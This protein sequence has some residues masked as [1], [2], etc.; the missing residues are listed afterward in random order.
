MP[1]DR[2][3]MLSER[4][5]ETTTRLYESTNEDSEKNFFDDIVNFFD[6]LGKDPNAD[7]DDDMA[8]G[9][10][11]VVSLPVNSIKPGGLRLFLMFYLMGMQ[12]TP[13]KGTWIP[14]QPTTEDDVYVIDCWF[15]DQSAVLT[16]TLSE[17]EGVTIDRTGSNPSTAYMMQESV[18][19]HGILDELE[20]CAF[21]D[22]IAKPDRLLLLK[23]SLFSK[24]DA[25]SK[26]RET[27]AF[28]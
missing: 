22:T 23:E 28:G 24:E 4:P 27:L 6:N 20:Q 8:A 19:I 10:T 9:T 21:D 17:K 26:A 18:I 11:R 12:N 16:I 2:V 1:L 7:E 3:P 14:N 5:Q 15:H 25:I 13:D